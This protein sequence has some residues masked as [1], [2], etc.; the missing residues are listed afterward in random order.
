M[1][2]IVIRLRLKN[3]NNNNS[4]ISKKFEKI[5]RKLKSENLGKL[6]NFD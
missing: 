1:I 4:D 6:K 5:L 3:N 2:I